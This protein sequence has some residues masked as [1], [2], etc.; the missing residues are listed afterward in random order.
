MTTSLEEF[1]PVAVNHFE[2][3]L[4]WEYIGEGLEGDY[5]PDDPDDVPLLRFS[6]YEVLDRLSDEYASCDDASYCTMVRTDTPRP[7]LW[8]AGKAILQV[9]SNTKDKHLLEQLSWITLEIPEGT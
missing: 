9:F 1:E 5:N 3:R 6:I 8:G 7:V 2:L 4:E